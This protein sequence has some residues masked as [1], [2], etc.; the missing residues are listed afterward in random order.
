MKIALLGNCAWAT[1]TTENHFR[2]SLESLGH[3]VTILEETLRLDG[4]QYLEQARLAQVDLLLWVHTPTL[5]IPRVSHMLDGFK[6]LGIPTVG[7]HLDLYRGLKR[8][9][10]HGFDHPWWH[11]DH[12]FSPDGGAPKGYWEERGIN[13]H[14]SPPGVLAESCYMAEPDYDKHPEP[15]I[16]VGSR[17]YHPE[18]PF[19]GE[20]INWLERTYKG[21]FKLYEHNSKMREHALNVLYSSAKVIIGDSCT[22]NG[23]APFRY[24]SDRV[25]ETLGR[26]GFLLH[27]TTPGMDEFFQDGVHLESFERGDWEELADLIEWALESPLEVDEIRRAGQNEVKQRHTYTTRMMSMLRTVTQLNG[28]PR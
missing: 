4:L 6:G 5:E 27:P 24:W 7:Y 20:L 12:I 22:I 16:F 23:E 19:R 8:E 3:E 18:H 9:G 28:L 10:Q 13:H 21:Q 2:I 1:Y 14:W 17:G 26:G 11:C 25:P 15:I